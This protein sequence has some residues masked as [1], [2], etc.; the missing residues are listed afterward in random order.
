MI[1]AIEGNLEL[2]NCLWLTACNTVDLKEGSCFE[3]NIKRSW[4][5]SKVNISVYK[6]LY[7]LLSV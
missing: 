6:Q 1:I 3:V 2:T 7:L 5:E 4:E